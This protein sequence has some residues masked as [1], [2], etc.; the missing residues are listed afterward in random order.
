MSDE[1]FELVDSAY[2]AYGL[3]EAIM[4]EFFEFS[5][6]FKDDYWNNLL[7]DNPRAF[8]SEITE[9]YDIELMKRKELRNKCD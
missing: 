7:A 5:G 4:D 9:A 3:D 1:D 6:G 8:K 2:N